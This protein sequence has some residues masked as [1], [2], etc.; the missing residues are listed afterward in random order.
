MPFCLDRDARV[1]GVKPAFG[2]LPI[3]RSAGASA[4]LS[5]HH[6][7]VPIPEEKLVRRLEGIPEIRA[8]VAEHREAQ[9]GEVL[10]HV[11]LGDVARFCV[12]AYASQDTEGLAPCLELLD[13]ALQEGEAS[14]E[15]AICVSF[16]ENVG[17]WLAEMRPFIETW[18][19]W[20]RDEAERQAATG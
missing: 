19:P 11:L 20:L 9:D 3:G 10:L 2:W 6:Q 4:G 16:V 13:V 8:L 7:H 1:A 12:S 5:R 18:P 17:P 14:V 15:N